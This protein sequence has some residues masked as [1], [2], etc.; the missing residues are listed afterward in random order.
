MTARCPSCGNERVKVLL[1]DTM[2]ARAAREQRFC[3]SCKPEARHEL[4]GYA[5]RMLASM[6]LP[7]EVRQVALAA[8]RYVVD[9]SQSYPLAARIID[10]GPVNP[11]VN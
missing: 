4:A 3:H 1:I 7:V 10:L 11:R 5:R 2:L 6:N 8:R 9:R